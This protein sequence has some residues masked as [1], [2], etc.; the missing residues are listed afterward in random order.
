MF[1]SHGIKKMFISIFVKSHAHDENQ[2]GP[3]INR[4]NNLRQNIPGK[5][6]GFYGG[7]NDCNELIL[8][9]PIYCGNEVI[10]PLICSVHKLCTC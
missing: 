7:F 5:S 8:Q 4:C 9:T 1:L 10:D 6:A 3:I 2:N